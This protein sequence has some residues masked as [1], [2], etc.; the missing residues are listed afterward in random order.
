MQRLLDVYTITGGD[1]AASYAGRLYN[2]GVGRWQGAASGDTLESSAR[3]RHI[4]RDCDFVVHNAAGAIK[5]GVIIWAFVMNDPTNTSLITPW[6]IG[7]SGKSRLPHW[8]GSR[9]MNCGVLWRVH[10]GGLIATDRV[11]MG[12]GYE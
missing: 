7:V 8:A 9:P 1:E 2:A 4:L 11:S 5:L 6:F 12:V 3:T 10:K